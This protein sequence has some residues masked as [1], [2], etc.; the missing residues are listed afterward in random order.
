MTTVPDKPPSYAARTLRELTSYLEGVGG[1]TPRSPV[2]MMTGL[3]VEGTVFQVVLKTASYRYRITVTVDESASLST[4]DRTLRLY[5][6]R[7]G[8]AERLCRSSAFSRAGW[9]GMLQ[10]IVGYELDAA[11]SENPT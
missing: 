8:D 5:G 9:Y 6:R 7:G 2:T 11:M 1:L 10:A 4:P 3:G